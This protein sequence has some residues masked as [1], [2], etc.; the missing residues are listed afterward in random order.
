MAKKKREEMALILEE[1]QN[2]NRTMN[3]IATDIRAIRDT[4]GGG[5]S[6]SAL[7]A[8]TKRKKPAQSE[9]PKLTP[10]T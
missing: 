5:S 8:P 10:P 3:S 9:T 1:L 7:S 4:A 6:A 2:L